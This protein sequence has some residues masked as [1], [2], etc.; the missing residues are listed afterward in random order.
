MYKGLIQN[1]DEFH[2]AKQYLFGNNQEQVFKVFL[3]FLTV[4]HFLVP[5]TS[6]SSQK[7]GN[8]KL[9]SLWALS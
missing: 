4:R 2:A 7:Q 5:T 9:N 1:E 3:Y 6:A 8:I